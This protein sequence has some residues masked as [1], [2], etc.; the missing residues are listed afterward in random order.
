ML[1]HCSLSA[2]T[3]TG[4]LGL[5]RSRQLGGTGLFRPPKLTDAYHELRI[6]NREFPV[7]PRVAELEPSFYQASEDDTITVLGGSFG[8]PGTTL[9][10]PHSGL[11]TH[12]ANDSRFNNSQDPTVVHQQ[13]QR[14][15][16][17]KILSETWWLG[18]QES[19][20]KRELD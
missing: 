10:P 1:L 9:T 7:M 3:L 11:Q 19:S 18:H 2:R 8:L 17:T 14:V 13:E 20:V 15:C 5:I 16:P 12:V 4:R 6:L